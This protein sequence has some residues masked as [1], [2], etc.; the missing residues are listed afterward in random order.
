MRLH[1]N[2][3]IYL[4][5]TWSLLFAVMSFYWAA[6]GMIGV[7][8]LGGEIYKK[9]MERD[10]AFI[11]VVWVTG[12]VKLGGAILLLLLLKTSINKKIRKMLSL[13]CIVA[14][15]FMI[16]YGLGNFTT[17]S[18]AGLNVLHFDMSAYAI[19]WRLII[20][21]PFWMIGG[22]LYVLAGRRG[23]QFIQN[24]F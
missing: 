7:E 1:K 6:G 3:A 8:S 2:L 13:F 21:E 11:S 23:Y 19:K 4:G 18:L 14:G 22:I 17:I 12:V 20:W 9:A 10:P 24:S 15:V 5:V 16:L